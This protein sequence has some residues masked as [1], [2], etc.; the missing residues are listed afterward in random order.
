VEYGQRNRIAFADTENGRLL[1]FDHD[2]GSS[3]VLQGCHDSNARS[4]DET[5][6]VVDNV[7]IGAEGKA[8]EACYDT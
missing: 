1:A 6:I 5:A 8:L 3:E 4:V 2:I 7:N